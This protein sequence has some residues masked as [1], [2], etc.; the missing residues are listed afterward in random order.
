MK[1]LFPKTDSK[2]NQPT[3]VS[4]GQLKPEEKSFQMTF[5]T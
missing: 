4:K 2:M 5:K 3:Y 1:I